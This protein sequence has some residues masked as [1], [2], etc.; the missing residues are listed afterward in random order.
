MNIAAYSN[1]KQIKN[2]HL[3]SHLIFMLFR[4]MGYFGKRTVCR[5]LI[6]AD[7]VTRSLRA[8]HIRGDAVDQTHLQMDPFFF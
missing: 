2:L 4:G 6:N 5:L 7:N 3:I 8:Y 1:K